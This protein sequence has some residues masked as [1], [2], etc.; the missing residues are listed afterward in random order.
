MRPQTADS[1]ATRS[2]ENI[3]ATIEHLQC[4]YSGFYGYIWTIK[5]AAPRA[6]ATF[7][8]GSAAYDRFGQRRTSERG[9]RHAPSGTDVDAGLREFQADLPAADSRCRS[10]RPNACRGVHG[11]RGIW[12]SSF[13]GHPPQPG[14]IVRWPTGHSFMASGARPARGN[15]DRRFTSRSFALTCSPL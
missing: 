5:P 12:G 2:D 10:R 13:A 15:D 6:C 14:E 4:L 8:D 7:R 1:V 3:S 9:N 11:H